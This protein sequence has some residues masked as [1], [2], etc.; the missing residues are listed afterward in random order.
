MRSFQ[1]DTKE[2]TKK[3]WT[4]KQENNKNGYVWL[5]VVNRI[6]TCKSGSENAV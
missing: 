5:A 4:N 1:V 2:Y 3:Q 6:G